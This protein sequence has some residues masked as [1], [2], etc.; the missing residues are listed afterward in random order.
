MEDIGLLL[1]T[2]AV[3]AAAASTLLT[4]H[5]ERRRRR[6]ELYG[7]MYDFILRGMSE[8]GLLR[9][10]E[11]DPTLMPEDFGEGRNSKRDRQRGAK[12]SA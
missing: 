5:I 10:L 7:R 6:A 11:E 12:A 9:Y 8:E 2:V 3:L 4:L 1:T